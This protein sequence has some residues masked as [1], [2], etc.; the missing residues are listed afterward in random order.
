MND[1][2]CSRIF[3]MLSEY[4]DRE[5]PPGACGDLED[6]LR[7]CPECIQFVDSLKRSVELCRQYGAH[8]PAETVAPQVMAD[9]RAAYETMLKRRNGTNTGGG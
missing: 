5:L 4:L 6:H 8:R 1:R 3:A 2:D 7:D 9:L